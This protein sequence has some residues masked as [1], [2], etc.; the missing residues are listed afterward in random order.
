L[1]DRIPSCERGP[2]WRCWI[3]NGIQSVVAEAELVGYEIIAG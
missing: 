1:C 2:N 3:E